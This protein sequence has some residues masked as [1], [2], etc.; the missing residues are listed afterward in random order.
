MGTG[1]G[2]QLPLTGRLPAKALPS[3]HRP[4]PGGTLPPA[5][6]RTLGCGCR[7]PPRS[8]CA[9]GA[10]CRA[11]GRWPMRADPPGL[12]GRGWGRASR[13]SAACPRLSSTP[14]AS[15]R[16]SPPCG[17]LPPWTSSR[18]PP[19]RAG[20]LAVGRAVSLS[21]TWQ[22]GDKRILFLTLCAYGRLARQVL[23]SRAA[24][25]RCFLPHLVTVPWK[26]GRKCSGKG[27]RLLPAPWGCR[28]TGRGRPPLRAPGHRGPVAGGWDSALA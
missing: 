28:W 19:E 27:L 12:G 15:A 3:P 20:T 24:D 22:K 4:H 8:R 1:T 14:R 26:K 2:A 16:A 9:A 11:E 5:L 10:P 21:Q 23:G 7:A 25:P 13:A 6:L 17:S 18:H